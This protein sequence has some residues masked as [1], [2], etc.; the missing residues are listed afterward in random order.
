MQGYGH[1]PQD[2]GL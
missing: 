2:Q 1:E